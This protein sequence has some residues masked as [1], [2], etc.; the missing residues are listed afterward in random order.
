M[1]Q[2]PCFEGDTRTQYKV[3]NLTSMKLIELW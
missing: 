2:N 3:M 1:L